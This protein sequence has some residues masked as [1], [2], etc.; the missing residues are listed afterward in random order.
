[1]EQYYYIQYNTKIAMLINALSDIDKLNNGHLHFS[2]ALKAIATT[3][4]SS[5]IKPST[6]NSINSIT[7]S[8]FQHNK[9]V[10]CTICF[11][12]Y[13]FSMC[14]KSQFLLDK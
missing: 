13:S 8:H 5:R 14:Q 2:M 3:A 6:E 7:P 4:L 9:Y 11:E 1:M 10:I 12:I